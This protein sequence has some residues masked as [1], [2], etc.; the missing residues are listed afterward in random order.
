MTDSHTAAPEFIPLTF[1]V[2][3]LYPPLA[4]ESNKLREVYMK[5]ADPC[6]FNEFKLAGEGQG[7]RMADGNNR[8]LTLAGDRIVYRDDMTQATFFSFCED[9][10]TIFTALREHLNVPVFLHT[11]VLI[12][13]LMPH[14]SP[15]KA[16]ASMENLMI[17]SVADHLKTFNRPTTGVGFRLVFP[18]TQQQHSTF[19]VRIEPYYRDMKLF[20]LENSAQFFDPVTDYTVLEGYF[21]NAYAFLQQEIGWFIQSLTSKPEQ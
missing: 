15:N 18:A 10:R 1:G 2:E 11:K 7:A 16:N 9:C 4:L 13:T 8:H 5:L 21:Q 17:P 12:R 3:T 19:N 14:N 20:F 6:R